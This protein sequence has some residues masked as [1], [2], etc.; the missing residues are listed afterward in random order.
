[1]LISS[2]TTSN[3]NLITVD[4]ALRYLSSTG[5]EHAHPLENGFKTQKI[6]YDTQ[7]DDLSEVSKRCDVSELVLTKKSKTSWEGAVCK[8]HENGKRRA[9]VQ[10]KH[11]LSKAMDKLNSRIMASTEIFPSLNETKRDEG[12]AGNK[13]FKIK[14]EDYKTST[15]ILPNK[16]KYYNY[17][18]I[19]IDGEVKIDFGKIDSG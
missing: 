15:G 5:A 1:M 17:K 18:Q 9:N 4:Q 8:V 19:T 14:K 7:K 2:T 10:G 16:G 11:K 12:S 6:Q 3:Q 13:E